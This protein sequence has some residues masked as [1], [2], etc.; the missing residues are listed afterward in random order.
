MKRRFVSLL[1]LLPLS[2]LATSILIHTDAERA[3][4]ADR[5]VIVEVQERQT[6]G[7]ALDPR[8]FTTQTRLRI[9]E[10]I[11]GTGPAVVT[12]VQL[13]G[14]RGD[15]TIE[16][17][18]DA[19]FEPRERAVLFLNCPNAV[20]R[21]YLVAMGEG[22]LPIVDDDFVILHDMRTDERTRRPL[23]GLLEEL[24]RLPPGK[25]KPGARR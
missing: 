3:L 24:R 13:G 5:V 12:L 10:N 8:K 20:D 17:A 11:R 1:A 7:D 14:R 25:V 23:K 18:G 19:T 9:I 21:C 2:G 4:A 6:V 16:I 15:Q 22:K